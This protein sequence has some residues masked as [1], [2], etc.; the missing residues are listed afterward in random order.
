M[1]FETAKR[2]SSL[3]VYLFARLDKMIQEKRANGVDVINL[4]IGD[5]DLPTPDYIIDELCK[6]ARNPQNHKYSSYFGM[7][8]FRQAVARWYKN[9]FGV[10]LDGKNEVVMLIGSKE[11][12]GHISWCYINPG[13]TALIPD[14]CYPV[15]G[16]GVILAGGDPYWM[17]LKAENGFLPDLGAIPPEVAKKAKL[18]FLC[19]PNNPTGAIA[20]EDFFKE[21]IAF[22]KEYEIL[23]CHDVAYS[24]I[25]YDGYRP[26]SFLQF[27]GAKEVGVE[28]GSASKPYNMTGWRIGWCAGNPDAVEALGRLKSNLDTGQFQAIQMAGIKALLSD[29]SFSQKMCDVY[30]ERRD[31]CVEGLNAMGWKLEKPKAAFYIWAPVP[32]GYTSGSFAEM[33]FNKADVVVTPGAGYGPT[34]GDGYIRISLTVPT[35]RL[36]EAIERIRKNVGQLTF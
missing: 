30:K 5:P 19:Y 25:A 3:P 2:L 20:T 10:E 6:E 27:P 34:E 33:I 9:R 23:I 15:Y 1:K 29:Q 31:I 24:D 7:P 22:A 35:D 28:F 14:P 13:D 32:A 8:A 16:N 17:P 36:K 4:G 18:M 21:A 11:G 26:P 12:I